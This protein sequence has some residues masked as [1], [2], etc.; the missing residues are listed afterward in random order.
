MTGM[1]QYAPLF[2]Q[3]RYQACRVPSS[4][5]STAGLSVAQSN[6]TSYLTYLECEYTLTYRSH[7]YS[8]HGIAGN[9][10]VASSGLWIVQQQIRAL[11]FADTKCRARANN[12]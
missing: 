12:A 8:G 7:R 9:L 11:R 6:Q 5:A 4:I 3:A 10:P 2:R 1:V